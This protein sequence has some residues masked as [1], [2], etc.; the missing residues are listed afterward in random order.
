MISSN[1]HAV[2]KIPDNVGHLDPE[3]VVE[4]LSR[5][6]VNVTEAAAELGVGSADLRRLLWARPQLAD[7][8]VEIEERRLD[9]AEKNIYEA[10]R[11]DDSRRR[12]AASM[13]TIRNSHRA[14]RRGWITSSAAS[15]DVNIGAGSEPRRIVIRWRNPG[16]SDDEKPGEDEWKPPVYDDG[17]RDDCIEGE[18]AKPAAQLEHTVAAEPEPEPE[19]DP[20]VTEPEPVG[21]EPA[22]DP[23]V[24]YERERIDAWIRNRLIAYPLASCLLCRKPIIAGQDWQEAS[25][26]EARARF[27]RACHIEWRSEQ[28]AAARQALGLEG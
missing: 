12:D 17:R 13:F 24:R 8:A 1:F 5:H 7:A 20:V 23:A 3:V 28:E 14:R 21:A 27:H 16:E 2:P 15:V 11:S 18:V 19:P 6:G 22:L 26:G 9:L 25:N 4:V 10:L